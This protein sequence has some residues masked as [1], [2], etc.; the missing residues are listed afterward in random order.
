M[1]VEAEP[2]LAT[3]GYDHTIKLWQPYSGVCIRS[4]Q[5]LDSQV[6]AL[7]ISPHRSI[8]AACGFQH[9]RLYD[10]HTNNPIVNFEGVSKNVTRIGFQEEEKF[11]FT[12]GED[13]RVRI[14][15]MNSHSPTCKRIFDCQSPV[16]AVCLHPNQVELAIGS[17]NGV[18]LWDVKSDMHEQLIP[19]VDASIQDI[20]ISSNGLFMAAVNNKGNCYVWDLISKEQQLTETSPRLKIDAHK[21]YALRC[22]FSPDSSML[23]TTSGDGTAKVYKTE[24]FSLYCELKTEGSS[25]WIWDAIFSNDSKYLFTASSDTI[26]RL[27]RLDKKTVERE[28]HGHQKAITALAFKE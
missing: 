7:E 12:G 19:E 5:H 28:Y 11:M 9:I 1:T 4:L 2:L 3:G 14:W 15:D 10:I 26:G 24:D 8:L 13:C 23:V 17:Q 6:N 20:C 18:Y 27:W 21:K 16:N 25:R 22:R